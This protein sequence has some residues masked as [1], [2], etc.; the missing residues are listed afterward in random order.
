MTALSLLIAVTVTFSSSAVISALYGNAYQSAGLV[1]AVHVWSSVF[2]FLGVVTTN[3]LLSERLQLIGLQRTL[4][5]AFINICLNLILIPRFGAIGAASA[6]VFSQFCVGIL[7]DAFNIKT[8]QLLSMKL[9]SLNP[10]RFVS[11][12]KRYVS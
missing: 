3:W 5:G 9:N 1:L 8:H 4:V 12:I 6:T 11:S 2:V 7:L 10:V